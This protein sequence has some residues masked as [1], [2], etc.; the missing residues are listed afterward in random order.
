M[1][2]LLDLLEKTSRTFAL[3]IPLLPEPTRREVTIAYLL[4]RIADTFEDATDWPRERR[5]MALEEFCGLLENSDPAAARRITSSWA[6]DVPVQHIGYLELLGETPFVIDSFREMNPESRSIV[7][8]HTVRTAKGMAGIVSRTDD[9]G[10]LRLESLQDVRDYCYVVAGIVGEMLTELFLVGRAKLNNLGPELRDRAARFGEGLQLVNI[11]KDSATDES[12]GRV[13]VPPQVSRG[14]LFKLAHQDLEAASE[15]TLA[16]QGAGAEHGL[17]AFNAL[18]VRLAWATLAKVEAEG[19]GSKISR[20]TVW[21]IVAGMQR[22]LS[23]GRP[24]LTP[25]AVRQASP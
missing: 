6:R 22:A 5:I 23:E 17:V 20:Q 7:H 18:P 21:E 15:Y 11:L 19:P 16:L 14:E 25:P 4:F 8:D 12:E 1:A 3:S 13:Y 9:D 24:A 2:K 10:V